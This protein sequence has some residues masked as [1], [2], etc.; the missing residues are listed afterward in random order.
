MP[1]AHE[2]SAARGGVALFADMLGMSLDAYFLAVDDVETMC[3]PYQLFHRGS[4][5][6]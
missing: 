2:K 6:Q 4:S 3:D 5:F 1:I